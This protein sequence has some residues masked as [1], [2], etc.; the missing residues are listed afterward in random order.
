MPILP[1]LRKFESLL[2]LLFITSI[3]FNRWDLGNRRDP[4]IIRRLVPWRRVLFDIQI[5]RVIKLFFDIFL[6]LIK[7]LNIDVRCIH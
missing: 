3:V 1:P 7:L 2:R 5:P 6:G 4:Q